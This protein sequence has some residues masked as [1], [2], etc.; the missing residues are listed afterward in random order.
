MGD[1]CSFPRRLFTNCFDT[2]PESSE[3][4]AEHRG[5]HE[6]LLCST[7]TRRCV[8]SGATE[9]LLEQWDI[10]EVPNRQ[11]LS[12][13]FLPSNPVAAAALTESA[14]CHTLPDDAGIQ[15]RSS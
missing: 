5:Y 3:T 14:C 8:S 1:A 6:W 10:C 9:S 15:L 13:P 7:D 2:R 12:A 11:A 4:T